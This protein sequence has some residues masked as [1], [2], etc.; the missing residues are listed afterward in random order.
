[1]VW[2]FVMQHHGTGTIVN[3]TSGAAEKPYVGWSMYGSQK[4]TVNM[5]TRIVAKEIAETPVRILAISP[6]PFESPMQ[7][8]L[9]QSK[10]ED[11]P[12][13]HKFIDL[14]KSGKLPHSEQVAE[15]I[16]DISLSQWPELSGRIVDIRSPEFQ[17]ECKKR[18]IKW[19]KGI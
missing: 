13:I 5:F 4:A 2:V 18:G 11:F 7:E 9:R 19:L 1:M 10:P 6:G 16:L 17:K 3:I 12:A 8:S 15:I 14:H